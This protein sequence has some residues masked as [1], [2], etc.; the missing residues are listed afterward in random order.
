MITETNEERELVADLIVLKEP[1]T[2]KNPF[3]GETCVLC[4]EAVALYD[5]IKGAEM[6]S[7]SEGVTLGIGLFIKNWARE[8]M[9]LLD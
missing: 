7:D 1:E 4:P 3:T 9:V 8:Y 5:F 6:V 2:V